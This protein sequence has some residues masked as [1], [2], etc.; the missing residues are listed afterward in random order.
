MGKR[1]IYVK[2]KSNKKNNVALKCK[3]RDN[4]TKPGPHLLSAVAVE[5]SSLGKPWRGE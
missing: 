1:Y 2:I 4:V 5:I 3:Q